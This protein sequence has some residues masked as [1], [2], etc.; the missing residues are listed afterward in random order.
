MWTSRPC[1]A[2]R[3]H[4][5]ANA[6]AACVDTPGA[7]EDVHRVER[8][9]ADGTRPWRGVRARRS[10]RSV[11]CRRTGRSARRMHRA[12]TTRPGPPRQ[13][14]DRGRPASTAGRRRCG[15]SARA[16]AMSRPHNETKRKPAAD[17]T[18]RRSAKGTPR[19]SVPAQST[20]SSGPISHRLPSEAACPRDQ[21]LRDAG[22]V[23]SFH[24]FSQAAS[25]AQLAVWASK[26]ASMR[27][28]ALMASVVGP[29]TAADRTTGDPG[30]V[31]P[32]SNT[33]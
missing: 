14:P 26:K 16:A 2:A 31:W 20:K 22:P 29:N 17:A 9:G 27:R 6:S 1:S 30:H 28:V 5:P 19:G 21:D 13:R 33:V 23:T 4:S 24:W 3:W 7:T 18:A 15:P 8:A 25:N 10:R 12:A 32:P 11:R